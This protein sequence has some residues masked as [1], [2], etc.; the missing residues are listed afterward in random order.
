MDQ[1]VILAALAER[2]KLRDLATLAARQAECAALSGSITALR[3]RLARETQATAS[4]DNAAAR[5]FE[6][7]A[8]NTHRRLRILSSQRDNSLRAAEEARTAALRS[9]GRTQ[10]VAMLAAREKSRR[11]ALQ[12]KRD[13]A[14]LS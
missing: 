8:T 1:L 7:F 3:E 5:S 4:S 9:F 14:L 11:A 10:A 12:A 2:K 6:K 13:E